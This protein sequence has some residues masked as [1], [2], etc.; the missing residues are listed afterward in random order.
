MGGV[1]PMC[2]TCARVLS[3]GRDGPGHRG[4]AMSAQHKLRRK[5]LDGNLWVRF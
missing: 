5:I 2:A 3:G 1:A 4:T